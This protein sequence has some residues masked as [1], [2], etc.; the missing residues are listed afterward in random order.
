MFNQNAKVIKYIVHKNPYKV[1]VC[2]LVMGYSSLYAVIIGINI[3][4]IL[5]F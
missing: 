1:L 2:H 5:S 4:V 3:M